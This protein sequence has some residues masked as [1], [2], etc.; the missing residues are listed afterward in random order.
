VY[1]DSNKTK[2]VAIIVPVEAA[3]KKL[4][5]QHNIPAEHHDELLRNDKLKDLVL[6][7]LQTTGRGG[8]LKG[9]ELIEGVV[10]AEEE[11]IP[12]NVSHQIHNFDKSIT[13][14]YS[15]RD[16]SHLLKSLTEN[17]S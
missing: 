12:Q 14:N 1:A 11:W 4:A 7:Q 17:R 13:S 16:L 8:G 10:L 3:L 5:E 15:L 2:P 6:K 9:I